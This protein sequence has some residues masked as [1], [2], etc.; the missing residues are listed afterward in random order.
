MRR[1]AGLLLAGSRVVGCDDAEVLALQPKPNISLPSQSPSVTIE[2]ATA[3]HDTY[4]VP[5][6]DGVEVVTVHAWRNTLNNGFRN[7]FSKAGSGSEK[8]TLRLELAEMAFVPEVMTGAGSVVAV[9]ARRELDEISA[10]AVE[11]MTSRSG[12]RWLRAIDRFAVTGSL[13]AT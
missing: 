5:A 1:F 6:R 9:S 3:V 8:V 13:R 7:A 10:S 11:S 2:I 12:E 4:T